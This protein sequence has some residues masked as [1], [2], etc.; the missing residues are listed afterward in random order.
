MSPVE[1]A[2]AV[3]RKRGVVVHQQGMVGNHPHCY[4]APAH[5]ALIECLST[6]KPIAIWWHE[7]SKSGEAACGLIHEAAHVLLG[8]SPDDADEVDSP[9]LWWEYEMQ[10]E[11][12]VLYARPAW[13]HE[14]GLDG[15][16][17]GEWGF[18]SAAMKRRVLQWSKWRAQEFARAA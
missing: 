15:G 8:V 6:G 9:M 16:V 3:V 7:T 11:A 4:M 10:R 17:G 1:R 13:M 14:F 2:L 18:A 5:S 12:K